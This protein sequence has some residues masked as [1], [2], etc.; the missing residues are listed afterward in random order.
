MHGAADEVAGPQLSF[1]IGVDAHDRTGKIIPHYGAF[2]GAQPAHLVVAGL[3]GDCDR[4]DE[5]G[6]G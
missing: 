3:N 5:D 2:A 1:G 6:A 4:L